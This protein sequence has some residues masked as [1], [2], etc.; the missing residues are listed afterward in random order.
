MFFKLSNGFQTGFWPPPL[1]RTVEANLKAPESASPVE[2]A[3]A[4][5]SPVAPVLAFLAGGISVAALAVKGSRGVTSQP[6][7][8]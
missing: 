3:T 6:L 2:T 8:G 4:S 5:A 1:L 7:L